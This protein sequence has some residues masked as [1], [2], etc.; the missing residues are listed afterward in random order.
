MYEALPSGTVDV[1]QVYVD[2][3]VRGI[4]LTLSVQSCCCPLCLL[5]LSLLMPLC[6]L[7]LSV[8]TCIVTV[9]HL[10]WNVYVRCVCVCAD[11]SSFWNAA[12]GG[13]LHLRVGD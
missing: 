8:S 9:P 10:C 11:V 6:C 4:A 7:D 12:R 1:V 3:D 2:E 5:M 13:V